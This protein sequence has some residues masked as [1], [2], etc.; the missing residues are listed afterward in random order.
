MYCDYIYYKQKKPFRAIGHRDLDEQLEV[1]RDLSEDDS[2]FLKKYKDIKKGVKKHQEE[3]KLGKHRVQW[4]DEHRKMVSIQKDIEK[5]IDRIFTSLQE[6]KLQSPFKSRLMSRNTTIRS[7]ESKLPS[8]IQ[9]KDGT[10]KDIP[11]FEPIELQPP[12]SPV[13]SPKKSERIINVTTDIFNLQQTYLNEEEDNKIALINQILSFKQL[14]KEYKSFIETCD[15]ID[16]IEYYQLEI[17]KT[18]TDM[19]NNINKKIDSLENE[20]IDLTEEINR[21]NSDLFE[22]KQQQLYE[23]YKVIDDIFESYLQGNKAKNELLLYRE[24]MRNVFKMR[25]D[26]HNQ[27]ILQLKTE[28]ETKTVYIYLFILQNN[29]SIEEDW[30]KEDHIKFTQLEKLYSKKN[31]NDLYEIFQ[32]QFPKFQMDKII[33]HDKIFMAYYYYDTKLKDANTKWNREIVFINI[34]YFIE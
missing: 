17:Y 16:Q 14:L 24:E 5:S 25:H 7:Q 11:E 18:L 29:Q 34:Y 27:N 6:K 9:A 32:L 30:N 19:K 12:K 4:V 33:T 20:Q 22:N 3:S 2:K 15:D 1:I 13:S 28:L 21:L 26:Q 31:K 23:N 8:P 10:N